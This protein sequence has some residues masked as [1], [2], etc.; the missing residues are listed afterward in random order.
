MG[1]GRGGKPPECMGSAIY[2]PG[3]CTCSTSKGSDVDLIRRI[4]REEIA[5]ALKSAPQ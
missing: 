5:K 4:V 3:G 1:C 2:G